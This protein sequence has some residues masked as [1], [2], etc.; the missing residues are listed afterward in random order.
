[1]Q[2]KSILVCKGDWSIYLRKNISGQNISDKVSPIQ[3]ISI[4]KYLHFKI[5]PVQN[6]SDLKYL[7]YKIS[8][9]KNI[10]NANFSHK[11]MLF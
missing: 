10:F 1:M 6:I 2:S 7:Q 4:Q 3:N 9:V 5:Y 8:L 11:N